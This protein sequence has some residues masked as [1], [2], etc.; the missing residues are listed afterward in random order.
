MNP[1]PILSQSFEDIEA[2]ILQIKR[3]A[4]HAGQV[5]QW[6]YQHHQHDFDQMTNLPA[7]LR[8][9]FKQQFSF[10]QWEV[11][12]FESKDGTTKF[13]IELSDREVIEAVWIPEEERNTLC[14][15]SQVG[16][17]LA[18]KF[19]VTGLMGLTRNLTVEEIVG[20]VWW[21]RSQ[22]K[23]PVSNIVFMGMGEPLQNLS[24]VSKAIEII[25]HVHG[26]GLGRRKI[27]VSTA[28][29]A[30]KLSS[31]VEKTRV[32]LAISLTGSTNQ[33]RDYWMPI[34][35]KIN[36]EQLI[37]EVKTI[38]DRFPKSIMFEVVMIKNET[39]TLDQAKS[40]ASYLKDF[41]CKVNLIP[42]NENEHF[43][44]LKRPSVESVER[45]RA[46]L[47]KHGI[48]TMVRRNRGNDIMAACGQLS[49]GSIKTS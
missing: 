29:L 37:A 35:Q 5:F 22:K 25:H 20:Q 7:D 45:Y 39:D 12:A 28:G 49:K 21:V 13:R 41:P 42:Y 43:P 4:F 19:C 24:N 17:A 16:C 1:T 36:L 44:A 27:S 3:P 6:I 31:F 32:N 34:N 14:I 48:R 38:A 11:E 18:C 2:Q 10:P 47:M 15:S 8:S 33:S 23:L 9:H 46:E 40:L 30:G 26:Y